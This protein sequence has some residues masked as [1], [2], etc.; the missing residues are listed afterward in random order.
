MQIAGVPLRGLV[1]AGGMSSRMGADKAQ[2]LIEGRPL[3][4][5]LTEGLL[6]VTADVAIAAGT[7]ERAGLYRKLLG[8]TAGRVRFAAD[9]FPGSGPLAG[10][11]AGLSALPE[12]YA[13]VTACDMPVIDRSFL[14]RLA[15]AAERTGADVVHAPGQPFHALYHTRASGRLETELQ[16]GRCKVMALLAEL[17]G[18]ETEPPAGAETLWYNLNTPED[19]RNYTSGKR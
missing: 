6:E 18:C 14:K 8:D 10:L 7:E 11:H 16:A 19:Y 5:R 9:R 3:L 12:G 1:L 17:H 15:E 2:L 4:A 13:F